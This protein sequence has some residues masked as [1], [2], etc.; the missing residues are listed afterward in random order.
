MIRR[1]LLAGMLLTVTAI[2]AVLA[3]PALAEP[4][5]TIESPSSGTVTNQT[6]PVFSGM[7]TDAFFFDT[8]VVEITSGGSFVETAEAEP[9]LAGEWLVQLPEALED[10]KY[11]AVAAQTETLTGET[12]FSGTVKFTVDTQP[13]TVSLSA[14]SSPTGDNT[15]SFKGTASD[16]TQVTVYLFEGTAAGGEVVSEAHAS[17][18]GGSWT[19]GGASPAL[20]DGTYT[21]IAEQKSSHGNGPG[22]SQERTFTVHAATPVVTLNAVSSP[23]ANS[24]PSFS[25][26]ASEKTGVTVYVFSRRGSRADGARGSACERAPAARGPR[27]RRAPA[28]PDGTYTA[29]AEQTSGF[30]HRSRLQPGTDV[31]G[32]RGE[33][34]VSLNAVSSP[35][36]DSTPSFS[37]TASEKTGVTVYVFSAGEVGGTVRAEAHATGTGGAWSS[38]AA[39]PALP[40]GTYTA[41]AEQDERLRHR[42]RLQPGTDVHGACGETGGDV[43]SAVR[44][45]QHPQPHVQRHRERNDDGDACRS[46]KEPRR[47]GRPVAEATATGTGGTWSSG[48]ASP[49]LPDGTYTAIA[50]QESAFGNGPG[51]SEEQTFTVHASKPV[52]TLNAVSS[53]TNDST[54][55]FS[56]TASE[57]NEVTVLVFAAGD[58]GGTVRAVA[59]ATGTGGSWSSAGA[60]PALPDGTYTA[61]A[62]Q[63]SSFGNGPG[64]SVER[65]FTVHT[66][67]PSVTLNE[68]SSPTGNQKPS[69]S[70]TASE[71]STV[72][73]LIHQ[74]SSPSG[75]VVATATG[76]GTG[77]SWSSGGASPALPSGTYTAVAEQ[78]SSFGNGPGFS[79][80][81]H[82]TVNTSPPSVSLNAIAGVSNNTT[83]SFTG[84]A[85]DTTTVEV[86]VY[87]GS[88]AGGSP[89]AEAFASGTGGGWSSGTVTKALPE[90][91]YTAIAVQSSSLGNPDGVSEAI[92]F[93]VV[94]A[95]PK[96]TLNSIASPSGNTTP[97]FTGTGTDTTPVTILIYPGSKAEGAPV[98]SAGATGTGG[99]WTSG[100]ASPSLGA[101]VHE[102]TA[103]AEQNS[104]LGNPHREEQRSAFRG[105]HALADGDAQRGAR[106]RRKT[107]RRRS[108]ERPPTAR[109]WSST[110]S[111][112]AKKKSRRRPAP[113]RAAAGN[114]ARSP[115][116]SRTGSYTAVAVQ[117]SSLGN[118]PG[119]SANVGFT[120]D[121]RSPTV[122]LIQPP[123]R[124]SDTTPSFSG[125]ATDTTTVTVEVLKAGSLV[126]TATAAGTGGGWGSGDGG[127]A[128]RERHLHGAGRPDELAREPARSERNAHVRNRHRRARR[129]DQ[130]A[131]L[132]FQQPDAVVQRNREPERNERSRCA[133]HG[134]R[135]RSRAHESDARRRILEHHGA[136]PG[137]AV[138]QTRIQSLRDAAEL[139]RQRDRQERR[140]PA[141]RRYD[142]SRRDPRS[143][144]EGTL[145][146]HQTDV[147]R[148]RHRHGA[149]DRER[150]RRRGDERH[151]GRHGDRGGHRRRLDLRRSRAGA[152]DGHVHRRRAPGQHAEQPGGRKQTESNS[153]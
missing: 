20:Q 26:T 23:T 24:K 82:F 52:V 40:D 85:S 35:T 60:S 128:A 94:T 18:S 6:R 49:A 17:V 37:G 96:V 91:S 143:V 134:R 90:G 133:R 104:S 77:G 87:K 152:C 110:S 55:S 138:G 78:E 38:G 81:I 63:E 71:K 140:T 67:K 70:G 53:P 125:T 149:R 97:S 11:A 61:V 147:Q 16:T 114:P 64:F 102:Y 9:N 50:E 116:P 153:S 21:A 131:A 136:Q 54:P 137:S 105:R 36:N 135:Q 7:T 142:L 130:P 100:H 113:R 146:Q 30:G 150:L 47:A 109:R 27:A 119:Q 31:H 88:S 141:G 123:A 132:A 93:T 15:P 99:S 69:F 43:E 106:P 145:E 68:V 5:L 107:P 121:T 95:S 108:A 127:D 139:D 74:G 41:V 111:T 75:S 84:F 2:F 117:S 83:P 86:L 101:G 65:T 25:G 22:F 45:D 48:A 73:V 42:S 1:A 29:V 8:V 122:T 57:K 3:S 148:N 51:F 56:G 115:K 66:A 76:S 112:A 32:A 124:S 144:R 28:L 103:V 59:H 72:T 39:A 62:E 13:P 89:V 33:T 79:E 12:G 80:P 34:G 92:H 151:R 14:V 44:N 98:S 126:A 46:S 118:P 4:A 19:S 129:D 10:G 58:V 120:V